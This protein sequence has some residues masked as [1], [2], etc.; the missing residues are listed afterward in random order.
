MSEPAAQDTLQRTETNPI[1]QG[2]TVAGN[3]F[4]LS[5]MIA[6][7]LSIEEMEK[8]HERQKKLK[9]EFIGNED[10]MRKAL[11]LIDCEKILFQGD[12]FFRKYK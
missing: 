6:S 2:T 3:L 12:A 1:T 5:D 8:M 7:P 10:E 9:N 11:K 4:I